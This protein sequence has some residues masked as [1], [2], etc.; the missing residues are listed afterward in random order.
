MNHDSKLLL[1]LVVIGIVGIVLSTNADTTPLYVN[2][3]W[4]PLHGFV[5]ASPEPEG[6]PEVVVRIIPSLIF[7]FAIAI[8]F[9]A[10]IHKDAEMRGNKDPIFWMILTIF[11]GVAAIVVWYFL[12]PKTNKVF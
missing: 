4:N 5:P 1:M 10:W 12:R 3:Q 6:Q 9:A 8:F 11:F 2:S 7:W